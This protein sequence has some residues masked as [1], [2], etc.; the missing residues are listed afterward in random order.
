[1]KLTPAQLKGRLKNLANQHHADARTLM[2]LYMMERFL[3]RISASEYRDNFIIKGG[4]LVTSLIGVALRS[5]MDIDTTIKNL[6]LSDEDIHRIVDE[7]CVIDLQDDVKF[8]VKQLSRIMDEMDYPGIRVTLNAFL[9]NM[10][11][12]MKIDISTGDVITPR[13]IHHQYKLLLEDRSILLWS[14]NLETL[15]SEKL[16]TVLAR[17]LLNTRM[18]DFYDLYELS[19]IYYDKIDIATLKSA[20]TATCAK[21]DTQNLFEDA[22]QVITKIQQDNNLMALWKSYQK[23]YIYAVNISY[24]DIMLS[25][26]QLWELIKD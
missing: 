17:G 1:M 16:Q 4:I 3:E 20:F 9:G 25:L 22:P 5:T 6:N 11:V 24:N 2:R 19:K 21:R 26:I 18:R 23:K 14:Y 7:I 12:P 15:L 13:E 10:P 8:Q